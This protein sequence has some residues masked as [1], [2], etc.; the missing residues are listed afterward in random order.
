MAKTEDFK[1]SIDMSRD[2][3]WVI[4]L[5]TRMEIDI[6]AIRKQP[7]HLIVKIHDKKRTVKLTCLV[8]DIEVKEIVRRKRLAKS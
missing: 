1:W 7:A 2:P 3:A 4:D 8:K 5:K 6:E